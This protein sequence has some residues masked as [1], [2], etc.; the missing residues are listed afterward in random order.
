LVESHEFAIGEA[1]EGRSSY[2]TEAFAA[3]LTREHVKRHVTSRTVQRWCR[4]GRIKAAKKN[5]RGENGEWS[6]AHSEF[7]RYRDEG[8]LPS[9][10]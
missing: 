2:T 9:K 4:E 1:E 3:K 7:V 5:G 8:L 6:I 10:D